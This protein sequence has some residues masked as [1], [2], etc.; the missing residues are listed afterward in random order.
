MN[1]LLKKPELPQ[2]E[3]GVIDAS[4]KGNDFMLVIIDNYSIERPKDTVCVHVGDITT[5]TFYVEPPI[6]DDIHVTIP[7]TEIPDG[8]YDVF[9][10]V[11]DHYKNHFPSDRNHVK[12][13]NS[14]S[15]AKIKSIL[16]Q[17]K[18][19]KVTVGSFAK[20]TA[21]VEVVKGITADDIEV[22]FSANNRVIFDPPSKA[23]N[24][25]GE[26]TTQVSSDK[27]GSITVTATALG[28][29]SNTVSIDYVNNEEEFFIMG[30]RST[31]YSVTN[32]LSGP[33]C[34]TAWDKDHN[35]VSVN[36]LYIGTPKTDNSWQK[37]YSHYY[38]DSAPYLPLTATSSGKTVT[39]N[40]LN[41][42][43]NGGRS[44]NVHSNYDLYRKH[45][46][47]RPT[48]PLYYGPPENFSSS[49]AALLDNN[50]LVT[51]GNMN[52]TS[53]GRIANSVKKVVAAGCGY[54]A[55]KNNGS[56]LYYPVATDMD[57][58][59]PPTADNNFVDIGLAGTCAVGLKT[60][61][62]FTTWGHIAYSG[63]DI[64]M[65][66]VE[67]ALIFGDDWCLYIINTKTKKGIARFE[68]SIHGILPAVEVNPQSQDFINPRAL[69]FLFGGFNTAVINS[70]GVMKHTIRRIPAPPNI[71][72]TIVLSTAST[73]VTCNKDGL[74]TVLGDLG[75]TGNNR[76]D[77]IMVLND[78]GQAFMH[79]TNSYAIGDNVAD[80]S[81]NRDNAILRHHDGNLTLV[82]KKN[83]DDNSPI[84]KNIDGLDKNKKVVQ[85]TCTA[86]AFAALYM[87]GT[88]YAWGDKDYG[89]FIDKKIQSQLYNVRA[90]Y[91]T[92]KAFSALTSDNRV[93]TWGN[94]FVT[95]HN[96]IIEN[97]ING[98]ISYY[99]SAE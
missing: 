25:N 24:T 30:A 89:G 63:Y 28:K 1:P 37:N 22:S 88:V 73:K 45:L 10:V 64:N 95:E 16:L 19:S 43:G 56:L 17:P 85:V 11:T 77:A 53:R 57:L 93:I 48:P 59:G 35:P 79:T 66:P 47:P 54:L 8:D 72:N 75:F 58:G 81:C 29:K 12:V 76:S 67:N 90:I 74:V 97:Y 6:P 86:E 40:P 98:N 4:Q 21:T 18:N 83:G 69:S 82:S 51:W 41:I 5:K 46:F 71:K 99:A 49:F 15:P 60:D 27:V 87:D 52:P 20:L 34:L 38:Y 94:E 42:F 2:K 68:S 61:G 31:L 96:D 70:E 44:D 78:A 13:I 9:Y 50:D 3:N 14:P 55:L 32:G 92:G 84:I 23:T 39:L 7:F 80:I 36:W 33:Q 26:A 62:T 91:A 65:S